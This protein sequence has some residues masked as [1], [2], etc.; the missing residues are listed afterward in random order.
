MIDIA[1]PAP[2][3]LAE[4][5][6]HAEAVV[7]E[8]GPEYVYPGA[9]PHDNLCTYVEGGKPSCIVARILHRHGVP[10]QALA[11]WERLNAGDM[12]PDGVTS[13]WDATGPTAPLISAEALVFLGYLQ[14]GQDQGET[15]GGALRNAHRIPANAV[16]V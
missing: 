14:V 10:I 13:K 15:W 9:N 12:G 7:A 3:T 8:A 4:A 5:Q 2:I 1:L 6:A 16:L 11:L